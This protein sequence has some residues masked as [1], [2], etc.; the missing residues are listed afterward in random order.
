M[1]ADGVTPSELARELGVQPK[2]IR[3]YLRSKY[4]L[5]ASRNET[6]W[7]LDGQQAADVRREFSGRADR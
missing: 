7:L 4:G 5:L 3:E 1:D 2:T 6:R